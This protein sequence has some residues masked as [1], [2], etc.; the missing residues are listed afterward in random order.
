MASVKFVA[1]SQ[2]LSGI[3]RYVTNREKTTQRLI[4]G[5]NCVAS[6]ACEEFTA[7]KYRFHKTGGRAY[8]HIIQSFSPDDPLDFDTAHELGLRLAEQF[9]DFQCLVAT[10][11]NTAHIH[12]HIIMNSVSFVDGR[13]FHQSA[14]EMRQVKEFVNKLCREYGLST[15]EAKATPNQSP[16]WK[17]KLR[18]DIRSVMC[19]TET[20]EEFISRMNDLGYKVD[21]LPE[22][23]YITYTTPGGIKCRDRKLFDETLSRQ[24]ME[25]YYQLGGCRYYAAA[26]DAARVKGEPDPGIRDVLHTIHEINNVLW[27]LGFYR[28]N[29][30]DLDDFLLMVYLGALAAVSIAKFITEMVEQHDAELR[31]RSA[32]HIVMTPDEKQNRKRDHAEDI[33]APPPEVQLT[34]EP[35]FYYDDEAEEEKEEYDR[36][37][38]DREEYEEEYARNHGLDDYDEDEDQGW[39]GMS[40]M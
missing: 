18:H 15:T 13:K 16:E 19:V 2:P 34:E 33:F 32:Y 20:K 29:R 5:V 25:Q 21:W 1:V 38:E 24:S 11:Q 6:S 36:E 9:P 23:K 40:M 27:G 22:H 39:G 3:I 30:T 14:Q 17:R 7:V 10:H 12:N 35:V 8:Y 28:Y 26:K 4:S 37:E 31:D